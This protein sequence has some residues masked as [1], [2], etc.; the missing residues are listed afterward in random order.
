[1]Y[2]RCAVYDSPK[3]WCRW[4]PLAELWYNT[5]HHASLGC[6]PF[7][8]LY[9][10]E[11]DTGTTLPLPDQEASE[12]AQFCKDRDTHL[13][14]LKERL[15]RAHQKMKDHADLTLT[16]RQFQVGDQVL[17][18]LQPYVQ[19]SVVNRPFPKLAF[20][21]FGPYRILEQI[22]RAAY[23]LD[24]PAGSLVHPVFHVPS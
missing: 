8:A 20:K 11:A 5:S 17:L 2:L 24:L 22:G 12:V 16:D 6:S 18:K 10:Y 9:G 13:A 1:M 14:L 23:K 4:L 7:K 3:K 21:Y 19:N 15:T